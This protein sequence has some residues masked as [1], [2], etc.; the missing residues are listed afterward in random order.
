MLDNTLKRRIE[1]ISAVLAR[2]NQLNKIPQNPDNLFNNQFLTTAALNTQ[3]LIDQVQANNPAL[4]QQLVG[5][6]SRTTAVIPQITPSDVQNAPDIGNLE[7]QG[8]VEFGVGSAQLTPVG[9]QT[10]EGLVKE[11]QEFNPQT[12]AVR[13]IGHTS[14][15]GTAAINQSISQRRAQVV[16][17][18]LVGKGIKHS[19]VAEGKGFSEPLPD[20]SPTDVRNQRT[21]IRLVRINA[22]S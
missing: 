3:R 5:E 7:I 12:V 19:I 18:F 4:A 13:V 15:T 21:Q 6:V 1:A 16:A 2:S 17:D 11:I 20:I 10:L 8:N 9:Q 14:K 22:A